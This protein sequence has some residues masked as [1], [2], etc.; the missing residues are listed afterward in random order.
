MPTVVQL[1]PM[2]VVLQHVMHVLPVNTMAK[3]VKRLNLLL[4]KIVMQ[5][6]TK[7]KLEKHR[8]RIV[9][10]V[11]MPMVRRPFVMHVLL[12]NTT[13]KPVKRLNLLLV[14]VVVQGN[15]K[16]KLEKHRAR[17]VLVLW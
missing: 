11:L 15:T 16:M 4:V 12:V 17:I 2:P 13:T 6:N 14:K 5:G 1:V 8:A 9:Q 3:P 7:T 10:Q